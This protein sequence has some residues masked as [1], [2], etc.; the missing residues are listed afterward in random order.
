[1]LKYTVKKSSLCEFRENVKIL[2]GKIYTPTE[3]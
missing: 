2:A 1:M 3:A